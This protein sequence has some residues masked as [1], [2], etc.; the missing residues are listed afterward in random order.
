MTSDVPIRAA[1]GLAPFAYCG[2][3]LHVEPEGIETLQ[4]R[5]LIN[6]WVV[7]MQGGNKDGLVATKFGSDSAGSHAI[8]IPGMRKLCATSR[9]KDF[10][11]LG[12]PSG[13]AGIQ[14]NR[15]NNSGVFTGSDSR[16]EPD[17]RRDDPRGRLRQRLQRV[18]QSNGVPS[19]LLYVERNGGRRVQVPRAVLTHGGLVL[20]ALDCSLRRAIASVGSEGDRR[21][22]VGELGRP[23]GGQRLLTIAKDNIL[24]G[25]KHHHHLHIKQHLIQTPPPLGGCELIVAFGQVV[26]PSACRRR[27]ELN[28]Q[29]SPAGESLVEKSVLMLKAV[30]LTV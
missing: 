28:V 25:G 19:L 14:I 8:S 22:P 16:G 15:V 26:T 11:N 20:A 30:W 18:K 3:V 29:V 23:A 5:Q 7:Q 1:T 27:D 6:G 12:V 24:N 17:P 21:K 2:L 9:S 10:Q 4:R 13:I